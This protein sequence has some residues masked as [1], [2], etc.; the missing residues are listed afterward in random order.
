MKKFWNW[1]H[2]DGGGRILRLEGPIDS[3]NFWGDEITPAMFR[4][5]L[6]AEDGDVTVCSVRISKPKMATSLSGSTRPA[7]MSLLPP[8]SIPC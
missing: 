2:D 4:E 7:G 3:E 1:I 5:D 6:E 8:R